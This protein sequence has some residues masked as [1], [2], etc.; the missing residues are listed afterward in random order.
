MEALLTS[1]RRYVVELLDDEA[2]QTL[3]EYGILVAVIAI[4]VVIA[5]VTLGGSISTMFGSNA[6]NL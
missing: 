6:G 2:G 3:A 5:A 1:F 4:V